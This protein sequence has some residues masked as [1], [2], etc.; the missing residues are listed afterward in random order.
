LTDKF[1]EKANVGEGTSSHYLIVPAPR[2]IRV[3][4]AGRQ[5][6]AQA[7]YRTV[8]TTLG[9]AIILRA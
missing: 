5:P 9:V 7:H 4:L 6:I 1:V 8:R 2:S 3:E